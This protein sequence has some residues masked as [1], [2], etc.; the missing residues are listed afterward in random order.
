MKN[1]NEKLRLLRLVRTRMDIIY[2]RNA[3]IGAIMTTHDPGAEELRD[4]KNIQDEL[5]D[6]ALDMASPLQGLAAMGC[7][8]DPSEEAE[9]DPDRIALA[10]QAAQDD[11]GAS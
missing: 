6:A 7:M 10:F 5:A 8:D 3:A 9:E 4:L 2:A 11:E 1:K